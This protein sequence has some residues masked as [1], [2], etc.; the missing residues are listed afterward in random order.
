[1]LDLDPAWLGRRL[2]ELGC[3]FTRER[4][5]TEDGR[6]RQIRGYLTTDLLAAATALRYDEA[7]SLDGQ[8]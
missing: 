8:L 5:T 4:V 6:T 3:Q 2:A 1:M 7:E